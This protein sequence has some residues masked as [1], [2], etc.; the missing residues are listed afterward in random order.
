MFSNT[1]LIFFFLNFM[2]E[3]ARFEIEKLR[4]SS[5]FKAKRIED[6]NH[7]SQLQSSPLKKV[8]CIFLIWL[9]MMQNFCI[10][11]KTYIKYAVNASLISG[12]VLL[13]VYIER[14]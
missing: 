2:Q 1:L 13:S 5:D 6:S 12:K 3:K 4:Q 10:G 11:F 14:Y 7:G 8:I 9:S